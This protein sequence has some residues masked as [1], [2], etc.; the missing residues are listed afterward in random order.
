LRKVIDHSLGLKFH[1]GQ[2]AFPWAHLSD[3]KSIPVLLPINDA[4]KLSVQFFS[5]PGLFIHPEVGKVCMITPP[6]SQSD[7][8]KFTLED[9][10]F[11][12]SEFIHFFKEI[13]VKLLRLKNEIEERYQKAGKDFSGLLE[14]IDLIDR[15]HEITQLFDRATKSMAGAPPRNIL[16]ESP[17]S[18]FGFL[19]A[20]ESHDSL[21]A[22]QLIE[23]SSSDPAI[24]DYLKKYSHAWSGP[25]AAT[26]AQKP[27]T[28]I[29]HEILARARAK[30]KGGNGRKE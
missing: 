28:S 29:V 14:I 4:K 24:R 12:H 6:P 25:M 18:V 15:Y 1:Q 17:L 10:L 16:V 23:Q 5:F 21:R 2:G 3:R 20:V 11:W 27:T 30:E 7:N 22:K 13:M 19:R 9:R 8:E 26:L